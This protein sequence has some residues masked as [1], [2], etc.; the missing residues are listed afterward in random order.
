MG[1]LA[2]GAFS[3][4]L[5][6]DVVASSAPMIAAGAL[7]N[8]LVSRYVPELHSNAT[9]LSTVLVDGLVIPGAVTGWFARHVDMQSVIFGC[10][11]LVYTFV[12]AS[13]VYAMTPVRRRLV[14]AVSKRYD[15]NVDWADALVSHAGAVRR[16]RPRVFQWRL[17]WLL[18]MVAFYF[19]FGAAAGGVAL[20]VATLINLD[21]G[22]FWQGGFA[23]V[24]VVVLVMAARFPNFI[25]DGAPNVSLEDVSDVFGDWPYVSEANRKQ[26]P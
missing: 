3:C 14:V 20:A 1:L 21:A 13:L 2:R 23:V 7:G 26:L 6:Q 15:I 18:A 16:L 10:N 12:A 8:V 17:G 19:L 24:A 5:V 25:K 22:F 4:Y 9:M 11:V